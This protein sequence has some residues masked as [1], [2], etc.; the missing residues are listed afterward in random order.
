M[1]LYTT[2]FRSNKPFRTAAHTISILVIAFGVGVVVSSFLLCNPTAK[3][4][5]P[6]L[7]GT[8]GSL[9]NYLL[10]LSIC[11]LVIDLIIILLPIPMI[12]W[13]Q[14][15]RRR[16]IE[17]TI[18]FTLGLVYVPKRCFHCEL[19][20]IVTLFLQRLRHYHHSCHLGQPAQYG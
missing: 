13:L 15:S 4:W 17:L 5:D 8:C 12:W 6:S 1:H 18:T 19:T 7:P 10:A 20:L 9:V 16:K 11:N 3:F 2:I 14:M